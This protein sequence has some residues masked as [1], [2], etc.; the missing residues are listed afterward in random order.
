MLS[1]NSEDSDMWVKR[2]N[3]III[4]E[5]K[6]KK[7]E[8]WETCLS[9]SSSTMISI[10]NHPGLNLRL[11]D[12]KLASNRLSYGTPS[13]YNIHVPCLFIGL[14]I[15]IRNNFLERQWQNLKTEAVNI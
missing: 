13:P 7:L 6:L 4:S 5:R 3:E 1:H 14:Y 12:E 2:D 8:G 15:C 9:A 11:P 10:R